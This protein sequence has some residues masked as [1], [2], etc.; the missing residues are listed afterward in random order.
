MK[1][2]A[3]LLVAG[4]IATATSAFAGSMVDDGVGI[5]PA[6]SGGGFLNINDGQLPDLSAGTQE[7]GLAGSVGLDDGVEWD[8]SLSYGIFI[9]QGWEVG[10]SVDWSGE[11]GD[12]LRDSRFGLFTE[13]NF[14]TGT[15]FVPFIGIGASYATSGDRFAPGPDDTT[16]EI[17]GVEGVAFSGELGVKYFIR[18]NM[19][20]TVAANY[21]WSPDDVFGVA[22]D[23]GDSLTNLEIGLR[24]YF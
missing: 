15:K 11:D 9:A 14:L 17:A 16:T 23:I 7:L 2:Y 8:L 1:K 18:S 24:F 5:Q 12:I 13:Y 10:F 6:N 22:D 4:S 20:I 19:A 21:S 3:T